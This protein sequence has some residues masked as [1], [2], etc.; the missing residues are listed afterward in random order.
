MV[1]VLNHSYWVLG[2][3]LGA[4]VGVLLPFNSEGIEFA[5]TALFLTVFLEQWLS[6]KK[7][8]SALVGVG[9]S[10]LCLILFGAERFLIPAMLLIALVLC[11]YREG[12]K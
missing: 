6:S 5:L 8:F 3:A 2:T 1:S 9:A 12:E 4:L 11:L 10:L 7:H